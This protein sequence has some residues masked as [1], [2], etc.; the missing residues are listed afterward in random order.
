MHH[1][2]NTFMMDEALGCARVK[3]QFGDD[4]QKLVVMYLA[5]KNHE[6]FFLLG[7]AYLNDSKTCRFQLTLAL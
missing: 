7:I 3:M 4:E 6:T 2:S 5:N 1:A